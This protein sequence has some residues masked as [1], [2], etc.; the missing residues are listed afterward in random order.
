M[1]KI[2]SVSAM[3]V[4][5]SRGIPT[6]KTIVTTEKGN[7]GIAIVPSGSSVGS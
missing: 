4:L 1:S 2:V 7:Y 3:E 5:D 6:I